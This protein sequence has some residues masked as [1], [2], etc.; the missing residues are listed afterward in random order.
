[1]LRP[2]SWLI[3]RRPDSSK[4]IWVVLRRPNTGSTIVQEVSV[5]APGSHRTMRL[6]PKSASQ[7]APSGPRTTSAYAIVRSD[8]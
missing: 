3:Q 5:A 1:M 4:P 6:L 7:S 8:R 2:S